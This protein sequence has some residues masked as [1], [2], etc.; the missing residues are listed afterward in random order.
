MRARDLHKW[1]GIV[2][3]LAL[4]MW[5]ITG[6]IMVLPGKRVRDTSNKP[7]DVGRAVVSPAQ[8]LARLSER[9]SSGAVRSIALIQILDNVVYQ[10]ETRRRTVLVNAETGEPYEISEAVAERIAR[11]TF[12]GTAGN[13]AVE[14]LTSYDTRYSS[15][16][17][18]A[19]RVALGDSASTVSYVSARNGAI[20][21]AD[22]RRRLRSIVGKLHDFSVIKA[23]IG[24]DWVHR[25]LAITACV[26]SIISIFTGYWLALPRRQVSRRVR[27]T[28][29]MSTR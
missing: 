17:L 22:S 10:V 20:V 3:G 8:A 28:E 7:L 1:M 24:A 27:S 13:V 21:S 6:I 15:G 19:F 11:A 5:T 2:I 29:P 4:L 25:G 16:D 26:L 12:R 14:R 18:P 9:D 23:V